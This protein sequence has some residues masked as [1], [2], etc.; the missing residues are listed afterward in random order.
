MLSKQDHDVPQENILFV[1]ILVATPGVRAVAYAFPR[2][3]IITSAVDQQVNEQFHI[4][5]GLGNYGDR[6]FGT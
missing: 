5:P 3:K 1:S 4:I 2:V 6:Y